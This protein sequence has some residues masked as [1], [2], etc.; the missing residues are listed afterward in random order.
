[1]EVISCVS[2]ETDSFKNNKPIT[3]NKNPKLDEHLVSSMSS[4]RLYVL[5]FPI[6]NIDKKLSLGLDLPCRKTGPRGK[7]R[8]LGDPSCWRAQLLIKIQLDTVPCWS[9]T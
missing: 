5:R 6:L 7:V 4:L 8:P 2:L 9:H 3:T 1:M